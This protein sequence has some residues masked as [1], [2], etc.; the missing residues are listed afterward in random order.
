MRSLSKITWLL[1][2]PSVFVLYLRRLRVLPAFSLM[3]CCSCSLNAGMAEPQTVSLQLLWKHQFQFAGYYIALEKGYYLD[4]GLDVDIIEFSNDK[5]SVDMVTAGEVEFAVGR[6][7]IMVERANG[8]RITALFAAFQNSPLM[9]LT[10]GESGI[11]APADLKG[12]KIMMTRNALMNAEILAMLL[13][14]ELHDSDFK[15]QDHSFNIDSLI[16]GEAEAMGSYLSNEPYQMIKKEVSYNIIHP[17]DYGFGM[18]S[19]ILFTSDD[20]VNKDPELVERFRRASIKGWEYAFNHIEETAGTIFK[21]Y[22]SQNKSLD[23]LV[24][25]GKSLKNLSYVDNRSFGDIRE[26]RF[27]EMAS[28]YLILGMMPGDYDLEGFVYDSRKASRT[29]LLTNSEKQYLARQATVS[30]CIDPSWMPYSGIIDGAV[31]GVMAEYVRDVEKKLGIELSLFETRSW[32][33]SLI[34][35]KNGDCQLLVGAVATESRKQFLDFTKPFRRISLSLAV[36]KSTAFISDFLQLNG[37]KVGVIEGDAYLTYITDHFPDVN[38]VEVDSPEQGVMK[39]ASGELFAM[40]AP[41]STL[42]ELINRYGYDQLKVSGP[43]KEDWDLA[44]GVRK[45]NEALLQALNKTLAT[46][47]DAEHLRFSTKW[48]SIAPARQANSELFIWWGI[49]LLLLLIFVFMLYRYLYVVRLNKS[50]R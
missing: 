44:I 21:H 2:S 43:M 24:F 38:V 49:G 3:L 7:S 11:K 29:L 40:V 31:A 4:E 22:N 10:L 39:V 27:H 12:R 37:R 32:I 46:L 33:E 41:H 45:G 25:E 8:A 42:A 47:D 15:R 9:L 20:L 17:A 5:N 48:H 13:K 18:Y 14:A 30:F 26:S 19:D 35:V 50:F 28:I 36:L 6:P 1:L 34:A 16:S 23:A